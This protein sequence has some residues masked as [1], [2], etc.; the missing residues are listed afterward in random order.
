MSSPYISLTRIEAPLSCSLM[1][2]AGYSL[3]AVH[4]QRVQ[5]RGLA[6]RQVNITLEGRRHHRAVIGSGE[7]KNQYC[8]EKVD[9]WLREKKSPSKRSARD[10]QESATCC[11]CRFH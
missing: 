3:R 1:A 9:K 2:E 5:R 11:L 4:W 7:F 8:K 10:Q 6:R